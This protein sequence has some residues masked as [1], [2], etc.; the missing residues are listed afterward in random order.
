MK[1]WKRI[2]LVS[3]VL[4][5]GTAFF[6]FYTIN[7]LNK[8]LDDIVASNFAITKIPPV[9]FSDKTNKE[10]IPTTAIETVS[11]PAASTDLKLSFI[12]PKIGSEVYIGCTYRLSFQSSETLSSVETVL[13]D[14]GAIK[15]IEPIASGLA[16]VNKIEPNFQSINW[17]VG[18]VW[19]GKYYIEVSNI[20]GV[21]GVD[22]ESKVF[23]IKKMPKDISAAEREK[24]C[25]ESGGSF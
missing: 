21:K 10:Q 19:S 1:N 4:V 23:T 18:S 7:Q 24:I 14:A 22:L 3:F 8:A 15:N 13:I 17:K 5:G 25:K 20:N 2:I 6:A 12:F 16:K 11:I 9:I